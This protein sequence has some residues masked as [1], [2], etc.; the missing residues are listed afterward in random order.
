VKQV[1]LKEIIDRNNRG[2]IRVLLMALVYKVQKTSSPGLEPRSVL[3][4][5]LLFL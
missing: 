5:W 3:G 4:L 1:E 2:L